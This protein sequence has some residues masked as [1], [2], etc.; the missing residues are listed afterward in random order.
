MKKVLKRIATMATVLALVVI[1]GITMAACGNDSGGGST[2]PNICNIDNLNGFY[3]N[4]EEQK[5]YYFEK[6]SN[7]GLSGLPGEFS[8]VSEEPDGNG[9]YHLRVTI[10]YPVG[11]KYGAKLQVNRGA[12]AVAIY[13]QWDDNHVDSE[14]LLIGTYGNDYDTDLSK[15]FYAEDEKIIYTK[16]S[17]LDEFLATVFPGKEFDTTDMSHV[18]SY[19]WQKLIETL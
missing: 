13:H 9:L 11:G 18:P 1:T 2:K 15:Q 19:N 17:G 10:N 6:T 4:V 14:D 5:L 8:L 12:H 7:G 3:A 16:I